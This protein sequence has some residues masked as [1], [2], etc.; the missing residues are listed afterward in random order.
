MVEDRNF[1]A[2]TMEYKSKRQALATLSKI[3][4]PEIYKILEK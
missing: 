4:N 1:Y 2:E 3:I